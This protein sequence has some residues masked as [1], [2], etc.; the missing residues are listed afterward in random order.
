M[1]YLEWDPKY[2]VGIDSVD[3]DHQNLIDMIN[4]VFAELE[5]RRDVD[6][7]RQVMAEIHME[8]SA[9]FALEERIMR[10]ASYE[11]YEAHKNDHENLL[12]QIR[13]MMDA[14]DEDPT[15]A[16]DSLSDELSQ[17]FSAHF[18]TFDARMHAVFGH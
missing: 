5:N 13:C 8:F 17:W 4:I 10:E 15:T 1:K 2:S 7:I 16:L 3:Y 11:E 14:V 18:A 9:H 12:D 6:Q